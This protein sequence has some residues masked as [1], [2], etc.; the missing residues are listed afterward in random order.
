MKNKILYWSFIISACGLLAVGRLYD[1]RLSFFGIN[2]VLILTTFYFFSCSYLIFSTRN[3]VFT[4]TKLLLYFFYLS[5]I[6][7]TPIL[8]LFF[9]V[10]EFGRMNYINFIFIIIP[11]SFVW[12]I[13]AAQD[14]VFAY[15]KKVDLF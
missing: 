6:I 12:V 2:L 5:V 11:I 13:N 4:K 15:E 1:E 3:V 7:I 10:T 9:G 14:V 8:W